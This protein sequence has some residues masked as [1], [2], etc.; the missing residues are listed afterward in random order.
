MSTGIR[1]RAAFGSLPM[2]NLWIGNLAPG[3]S[4]DDL[5]A[6]LSKYGFPEASEIQHVEAD[7]PRPAALVPY[8]GLTTSELGG[9]AR[10]IH[11][12]YWRGRTL[13]VQVV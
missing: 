5:R 8:H 2:A 4:D 6:F 9:L 13:N 10:R 11:D 7:G 12:V 1:L 3:V